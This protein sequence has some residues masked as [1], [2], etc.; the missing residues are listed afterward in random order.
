M[1]MCRT[2]R[3]CRGVIFWI[4]TS[5]GDTSRVP[6]VL[7][8]LIWNMDCYPLFQ[9][10]LAK[11]I[12]WAILKVHPR[13]VR[14]GELTNFYR[15]RFVSSTPSQNNWKVPRVG[16]QDLLIAFWIIA[17]AR[18]QSTS[19][20]CLISLTFCLHC[21]PSV[22]IASCSLSSSSRFLWVAWWNRS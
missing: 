21:P 12:Y 6:I 2:K 5:P 15:L 19:P 1:P 8:P 7:L 4:A 20:R 22:S 13:L 10:E 9:S 17:P 11:Y 16:V 18:K 14:L 3:R